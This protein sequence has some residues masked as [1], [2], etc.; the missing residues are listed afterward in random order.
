M[1]AVSS[2]LRLRNAKQAV[3]DSG[4]TVYSFANKSADRIMPAQMIQKSRTFQ[5]HSL[6]VARRF[7]G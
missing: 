1:I 3:K 7:S 6:T 4:T 5:N 2:A